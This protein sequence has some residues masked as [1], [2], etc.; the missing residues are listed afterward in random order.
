MSESSGP[1]WLAGVR[2]P[3]GAFCAGAIHTTLRRRALASA[4]AYLGGA[5]LT[6]DARPGDHER[7]LRPGCSAHVEKPII[8]AT[9]VAEVTA[10]SVGTPGAAP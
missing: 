3:G 7:A 8:P 6:S 1:R 10:A 2:A 9:F 4:L 5:L